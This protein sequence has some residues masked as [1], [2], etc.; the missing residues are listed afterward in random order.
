[1]VARRH[2]KEFLAGAGVMG[3]C[4][5]LWGCIRTYG[6]VYPHPHAVAP[7]EAIA[8]NPSRERFDRD[9]EGNIYPYGVYF[10]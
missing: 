10:Q 3:L 8:E 9:P 7:P 5:V 4:T 6:A 1:M 2:S